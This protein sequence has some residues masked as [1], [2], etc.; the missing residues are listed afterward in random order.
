[1]IDNSSLMARADK[2]MAKRREGMINKWRILGIDDLAVESCGGKIIGR[3][4]PLPPR[5]LVRLGPRR[6]G[7]SRGEERFKNGDRQDACPTSDASL[8]FRFIFWPWRSMGN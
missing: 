3:G 8:A 4:I 7:W 5:V 2:T 6:C 1:M